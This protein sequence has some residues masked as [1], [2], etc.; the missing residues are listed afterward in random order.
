M[1]T[2]RGFS[3]VVI[4]P[5][6]SLVA[7]VIACDSDSPEPTSTPT[8]AVDRATPTSEPTMVPGQTPTASPSP[9]PSGP[10]AL[11]RDNLE[12]ARTLLSYV[13]DSELSR[14]ELWITDYELGKSLL[15]V[16]S[17]DPSDEEEV[18]QYMLDLFGRS[19]LTGGLIPRWSYLA[20]FDYRSGPVS[21]RFASRE[22]IGFAQGDLTSS[23]TWG[24]APDDMREIVLG[25]IDAERAA[26]GI[27]GCVDCPQYQVDDS[28]G[29]PF[30]AWGDDVERDFRNRY[31]L[32]LFDG[33]G[34]GGRL[35]IAD[36]VAWRSLRSES[37]RTMLITA[38][39]EHPS[40]GDNDDFV[41]LA[42]VMLENNA[43][44]FKLSDTTVGKEDMDVFVSQ[45]L[46]DAGYG[47]TVEQY[48]Q[49]KSILEANVFPLAFDVFGVGVGWDEMIG[50][51]ITIAYQYPSASTASLS[52][53]RVRERFETGVSSAR[54]LRFDEIY[55]VMDFQVQGRTIVAKLSTSGISG[56]ADRM[57]IEESLH[58][59]E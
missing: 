58:L 2:F 51:N 31:S 55:E 29:I 14:D 44:S 50:F 13:P 8:A 6:V 56:S 42:R 22:T 49:L 45:I 46:G 32:P 1:R 53:P 18:W 24:I 39:G 15:G 21:S 27:Y 41:E 35:A 23:I 25:E 7:L 48:E 26:E 12:L 4:L 3:V 33:S 52:L 16:A 10:V 34:I 59:H 43:Y 30:F 17:P 11:E 38:D 19:G 57:L 5:L 9:T 28:G 37:M 36:G 47:L 20:G 40:L 54:I